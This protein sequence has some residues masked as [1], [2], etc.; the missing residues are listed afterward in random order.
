LERSC[1]R[2]EE[3]REEEVERAME[4]EGEMEREG[5]GRESWEMESVLRRK[6]SISDSRPT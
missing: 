2:E 3:K 4:R 1:R 5:G 6:A